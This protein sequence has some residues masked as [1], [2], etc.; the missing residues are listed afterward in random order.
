MEL[1]DTHCH[2]T[3]EDLLKD[4]DSVLARSVEAN[5]TSWINVGT[6]LDQTKKAIQ[7]AGENEN[8]FA[9]AG[10]HPHDADSVTAEDLAELKALAASAKIVAI[11]ETGLD[12]Y[13]DNSDRYAQK[14]LFVQEIEIAKQLKLPLIIH[15]REA[16]DE[17]LDI[18][19]AHGQGI[20]KI[21]FHC[22]GGGENKAKTLLDRGYY[23]S[24]TGIV[25]FKKADLARRTAAMVPL[26]RLMVET[27]C[28]FISPEPMRN[29]KTNEPALMI[30]TAKRIAELHKM[31]LEEFAK[32][33]T[34][35]AKK[36]FNLPS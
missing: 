23:I 17:T 7:L 27:D 36:F 11:G 19:D 5:V 2:L 3:F 30:H 4:V 24:F 15:S 35:T 26:N 31:S 14:E 1:I 33:T 21:V 25:T 34:Q 6:T 22:F 10:I 32:K 12:F 16:F 28:P 13:Y 29:Q 20:E 9:T 8:V 18:L